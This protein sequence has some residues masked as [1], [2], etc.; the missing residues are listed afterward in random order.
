MQLAKGTSRPQVSSGTAYFLSVLSD[1]MTTAMLL[2]SPVSYKRVVSGI[3]ILS[4]VDLQSHDPTI[5]QCS[6]GKNFDHHTDGAMV[7]GRL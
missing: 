2:P 7:C 5:I 4:G 3:C 1:A 6:G